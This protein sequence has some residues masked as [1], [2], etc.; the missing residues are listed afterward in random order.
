MGRCRFLSVWICEGKCVGLVWV[1]GSC[2]EVEMACISYGCY[3]CRQRPLSVALSPDSRFL[4]LLLAFDF[5]YG[6]EQLR[7]SCDIFTVQLKLRQSILPSA[8]K[9]SVLNSF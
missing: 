4:L 1:L 7:S 6:F 5:R 9:A 3:L 8:L 2:I